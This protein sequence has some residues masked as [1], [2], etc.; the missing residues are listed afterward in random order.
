ME[1]YYF[2][3]SYLNNFYYIV[4]DVYGKIVYTSP[5]LNENTDLSAIHE[6]VGKMINE[7]PTL[8]AY[9]TENSKLELVC[10]TS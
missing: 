4:I 2:R 9:I 10:V 8:Y 1:G 3:K 5:V 7:D 6:I